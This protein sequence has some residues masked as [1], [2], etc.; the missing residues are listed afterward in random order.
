M[1]FVSYWD[2]MKVQSFHPLKLMDDDILCSFMQST[3]ISMDEI[4]SAWIIS[5]F[6][7]W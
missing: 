3:W 6:K 7:W 4:N 5:N 2:F 1:I